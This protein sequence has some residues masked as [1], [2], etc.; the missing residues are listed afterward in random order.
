MMGASILI[1]VILGGTAIW[2]AC[3]IKGLLVGESAHPEVV[4]DIRQMAGK[5]AEI[6]HVNE[7][8]TLHMGPEFILVNL[9]VDFKNSLSA[10]Q[11]ERTV[12]K[13]DYQIKQ[14]Y[15]LVK[16]V[17]IEGEAR[18]GVDFMDRHPSPS[19]LSDRG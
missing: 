12:Q 2:L 16:R 19:L 9:S 4:Q 1:G 17:F 11:V 14:T 7:I 8:L 18:R 10:D 3:E 5:Y 15:P 13:L 6:E